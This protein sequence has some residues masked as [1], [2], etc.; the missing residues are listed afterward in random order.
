MLSGG[1]HPGEV[2]QTPPPRIRKAGGTHLTGML[3]YL[4]YVNSLSMEKKTQT[5]NHHYVV[6]LGNFQN[7][8]F[9]HEGAP[10]FRVYHLLRTN[11]EHS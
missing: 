1:L 10:G 6:L 9:S 7:I 4:K 2:G 3:S 5:S 11:H 8:I